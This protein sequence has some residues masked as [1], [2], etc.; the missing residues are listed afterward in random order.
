MQLEQAQQAHQNLEAANKE[1]V[2]ENELLLLQLHQVQEELETTVLQMQQLEQV[3]ND[4][5]THQKKL[6]KQIEQLTKACDEQKKLST[7]GQ[8]QLEKVQK[9][10]RT[11]E[12][13]NN[14]AAQENELLLQQLHQVQEEL[15]ETFLR[16]QNL[17]QAHQRLEA[18]KKEAVKENE[19]LSRELQQVREELLIKEG[20]IE[21]QRQRVTKLKQTVSWKITAP[22]RGIAKPFKRP[23]KEQKKTKDKSSFLKIP[24][25][26]TRHGILLNMQMWPVMAPTLSSTICVMVPQRGEIH[27]RCLIHSSTLNPILT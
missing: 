7:E 16:N 17:K 10:Y 19:T 9:D 12:A 25:S 26:S 11:L 15:E 1:T 22:M 20:E 4:Q 8:T 18:A 24:G 3:K 27:H 21:K 14:E 23:S 13:A 5:T 6:Q 2:Q